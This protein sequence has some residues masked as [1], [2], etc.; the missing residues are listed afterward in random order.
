MSAGTR[1]S[2]RDPLGVHLD[3]VYTRIDELSKRVGDLERKVYIG[4]GGL[5]VIAILNLITNITQQVNA[6]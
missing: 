1:G 3:R 6:S 2:N 4:T 5:G